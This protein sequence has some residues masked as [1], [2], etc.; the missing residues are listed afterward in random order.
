MRGHTKSLAAGDAV[1]CNGAAP[2]A[3]VEDNYHALMAGM[4]TELEFIEQEGPDAAMERDIWH[5]AEACQDALRVADESMAF[6]QH[7]LDKPAV[8]DGQRALLEQEMQDTKAM[9]EYL[10]QA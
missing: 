1:E 7:L 4:M 2:A 5:L 8:G 6:L 9:A 3:P 10:R